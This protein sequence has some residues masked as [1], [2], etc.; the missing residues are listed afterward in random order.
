[1]EQAPRDRTKHGMLCGCRSQPRPGQKQ[2]GGAAQGKFSGCQCEDEKDD[3]TAAACQARERTWAEDLMVVRV[4]GT[5]FV[6]GGTKRRKIGAL[7]FQSH[8]WA[9]RIGLD[10]QVR[11]DP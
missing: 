3:R 5:S 8:Q 7:L 6:R 11:I 9:P 4:V 2:D 1:M 10:A